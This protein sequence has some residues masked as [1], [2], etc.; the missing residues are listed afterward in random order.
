MSID[1]VQALHHPAPPRLTM[2]DSLRGYALVGLFLVHMTGYFELY[3]AR[4]VPSWVQETTR[5]LFQGKSFSLLALCFGFS[6]HAQLS[7]A[8]RR[9]E[10]FGLRFGWRM[11]LLLAIGW[12]HAL[13]YRGDIL[14]V[15]AVSGLLLIPLDRI[16]SPRLLVGLA[17]LLLIQPLLLARIAAGHAGADWAMAEP[18]FY[19]DGGALAPSLSGSFGALVHANIRSG[20]VAKWSFFIETGRMLQVIGL[21]LIGMQLARG[22]VYATPGRFV[23]G[24]GATLAVALVALA[25]LLFARDATCCHSVGPVYWT[26]MLVSGWIDLAGTAIAFVLFAGGWIL[27]SGRILGALAP[28]GQM[29]LTLYVGQSLVFVPVFYGF[30]LHLWDRITQEEALALGVAAAAAQVAGAHLWFGRFAYGPLEWLWR[31]GTRLSF[32]IP[33][34][35]ARETLKPP[36]E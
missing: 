5:L 31:A 20:S 19:D 2:V 28:A 30:G 33:F 11:A 24:L 32:D 1:P 16:R 3:N 10:A 17:A 29:T 34:L 22:G 9:G 23:R 27:G 18:L 26:N 4:P 21:F 6:F 14:M 35:R 7:G 13:I 8:R 12:L 36:T 25:P 15:L